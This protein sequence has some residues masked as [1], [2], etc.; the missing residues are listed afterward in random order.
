MSFWSRIKNVIRPE[1]HQD[2][3]REEVDFHLEMDQAN[4]HDVREARLRLGNPTRIAE[5]TREVGIAALL[6]SILQDIRYAL[7]QIR[8]SPGLS[9][10]VLLSLAFGLGANTA[11]FSLVDAAI[12][13]PLPVAD[14]D[15]LVVLE[16]V[17]GGPPKGLAHML[18][19]RSTIA[20]GRTQ[21]NSI[22]EALYRSLATQQ[23]AFGDLIGVASSRPIAI[24]NGNQPAEQVHIQYV[25]ENYFRVLGVAPVVGRSFLEEDDRRGQEPAVVVSH[26]YWTSRLGANAAAIDQTIRINSIPTRIVGVAPPGFFG[27]TIGEWID[28]YATL[29]ARPALEPVDAV[30]PAAGENAFW[31][32]RPMARLHPGVSGAAA[33]AQI[34]GLFRNLTAESLGT[35]VEPALELVPIPGTRGF[36]SLEERTADALWILMLL[37]GV[38]L[39]IVCANVANLLLSRSVGRQRESA[40]RLALGAPRIR[41]FRQHLIESG[42]FALLGGAAGVGLG[43]IL[44]QS[45]HTLFQAGRDPSNAFNLGMDWRVLAYSAALA[46]LTGLV[47]GMA[48]S[49]GAAKAD[50][51]HVLKGHSRSVISGGLRLPR[52]LVSFQVALCFA[53][54]IAAGLLIRSMANLTSIDVGFRTGNL[55]YATLNPGQAGYSPE[56]AGS[57]LQRLLPELES[58]AGVSAV[59]PV[60]DRLLAGGGSFS[61]ASSPYGPALRLDN[62]Q[63]NPETIVF[64]VAGGAG[65][66]ET[67]GIPLLDGS[68]LKERDMQPEAHTAVVDEAFAR[69]F[70]PGRDPVG[71]QFN[72][73]GQPT[74]IV[75]LVKSVRE[76]KV[77]G[78]QPPA[79]YV[80]MNL[81]RV[82]GSLHF[83]IRAS[84]APDQLAPA[85]RQRVAS[86]DPAV[87]VVEFLSQTGLEARLFRTERLLAFV[88]TAFGI[89]AM[90]LAAIGLFGVLAYAVARRRNE[91][92]VRMALG[93]ASGDIIKMVLR[94]SLWMVLAGLL[95]G[96]PGAYGVARFLE[97]SLFGLGPFDAVSAG[98][99]LAILLLVALTAAWLPARR[100]ARVNPVSALREE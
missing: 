91:I 43:Y 78:K 87:P 5:E 41:L 82:S 11:I 4:G 92:G 9:V 99:A 51:N 36:D 76:F 65:M 8:R 74:E 7:R 55:Y 97:A 89:V 54:L 40:V 67:L 69:T 17:N 22:S 73:N 64:E 6:E 47:F 63:P 18:G 10:A 59:A 31:W 85:V 49:W 15:S 30:P 79:I 3:I 90:L 50:V 16:W 23:T 34:N 29:A 75:G 53:A 98:S 44:A 57:F 56:Q 1:S 46:I 94:D 96:L 100:A 37:V 52:F 61:S 72:F 48:P 80:P 2:E 77:R 58:L 60:A 66:I 42:L 20:D 28:V 70:F 12:L 83:A 95:V 68:T 21:G 13:K 84:I 26:R 39:L 27:T 71:Q 38:L 45:M 81:R 33:T 35:E 88:S 14:P 19:R 32:V 24:S 25:S 93:A 62:G 86:V